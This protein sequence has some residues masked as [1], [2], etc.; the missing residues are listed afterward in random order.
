MPR[1]D[2]PAHLPSRFSHKNR[3]GPGGIRSVGSGHMVNSKYSQA[4]KELNNHE[5]RLTT[6]RAIV[7]AGSLRV[8]SCKLLWKPAVLQLMVTTTT[9]L[10]KDESHFEDCN[11]G[12]DDSN[13]D[14]IDKIP[15]MTCPNTTHHY[16]LVFCHRSLMGHARRERIELNGTRDL[17]EFVWG[18]DGMMST[19]FEFSI[20]YGKRRST[21][22]C[23]ASNAKDYLQWTKV[24]RSAVTFQGKQ[25][26]KIDR[27]TQTSS[28]ASSNSS[29]SIESFYNA[30][31]VNEHQP[32]APIAPRLTPRRPTNARAI[33]VIA[34]PAIDIPE[35]SALRSIPANI[36]AAYGIGH[37]RKATTVANPK[38][39]H[40]HKQQQSKPSPNGAMRHQDSI[41]TT[42]PTKITSNNE[43]VK[44]HHRHVTISQPSSVDRQCQRTSHATRE[45]RS[46]RSTLQ[47][48]R[49]TRLVED[50]LSCTSSKFKKT[51]VLVL[52]ASKLDEQLTNAYV[53]SPSCSSIEHQQLPSTTCRPETK[54]YKTDD[55]CYSCHVK[56]NRCNVPDTNVVRSNGEKAWTVYV[57]AKECEF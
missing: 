51:H 26:V 49:K 46:I 33:K 5:N 42:V 15:A 28:T 10:S 24:L 39:T 53:I 21:L 22:H 56:I 18:K 32:V 20:V 25:R 14:D 9:S 37:R 3:I 36:A 27:R 55:P 7:C 17:V 52:P 44:S 48:V 45:S 16:S 47:H 6:H 11:D 31:V 1:L 8:R 2:F 13:D 50:A 35:G 34:P 4:R 19:R 41:P 38:E 54:R 12:S 40:V 57:N 30:S 43:N 29:L 23:R